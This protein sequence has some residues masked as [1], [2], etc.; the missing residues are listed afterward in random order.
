MKCNPF[1]T[2]RPAAARHNTPKNKFQTMDYEQNGERRNRFNF[3]PLKCSVCL[4]LLRFF[5]LLL[6]IQDDAERREQA[7][8]HYGLYVVAGIIIINFVFG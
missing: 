2:L 5:F 8:I 4:H 7:T 6:A 3:D 1:R